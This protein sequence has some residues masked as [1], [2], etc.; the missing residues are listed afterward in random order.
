MRGAYVWAMGLILFLAGSAFAAPVPVL[1]EAAMWKF[2]PSETVQE[3][4]FPCSM[5]PQYCEKLGLKDPSGFY[6]VYFE[7]GFVL[8]LLSSGDVV[9]HYYR[10]SDNNLEAFR[11]NLENYGSKTFQDLPEGLKKRL[12]LR[13]EDMRAYGD[14]R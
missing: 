11:V 12:A 10:P 1:R 13:V 5:A 3:A 4:F 2:Y 9:E 8:T 7:D 6:K 14:K